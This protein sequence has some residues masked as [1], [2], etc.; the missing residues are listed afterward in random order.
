MYYKYVIVFHV[1]EN[2]QVAWLLTQKLSVYLAWFLVVVGMKNIP[3]IDS[4]FIILL[5]CMVLIFPF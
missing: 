2:C 5:S 3:E 4:V 1:V